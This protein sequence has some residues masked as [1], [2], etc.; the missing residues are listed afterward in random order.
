MKKSFCKSQNYE[1][2][3]SPFLMGNMEFSSL[4]ESCTYYNKVHNMYF[5]TITKCKS[6]FKVGLILVVLTYLLGDA[7]RFLRRKKERIYFT[8]LCI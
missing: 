5:I 1:I 4:F 2:V 8:Y 3:R 6:N 7:G